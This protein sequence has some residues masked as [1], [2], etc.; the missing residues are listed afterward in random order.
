M[1]PIQRYLIPA[2]VGLAAMHSPDA[3]AQSP[4]YLRNSNGKSL[5]TPV[6][7][8]ASNNVIFAGVGTTTPSQYSPK[9]DGIAILGAG[10]GDPVKNIGFEFYITSIDLSQWKEYSAS[11]QLSR[12]LGEGSAV[13]VG[14]QRLMITDGGD[15][16]KSF[17]AVYSKGVQS[18]PYINEETGTSKLTYSIGVGSGVY[19]DKSPRDV[20]EGRG[21]HG[22]YVFG[23]IAYEVAHSFNVITDWNGLNLNAG[24]SK[25]L[26]ISRIPVG[27]TLGVADLTHNSGDG[28]RLIVALSTGFAL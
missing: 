19:G 8:G 26:F 17:Y 27:V 13:G 6:A 18:H 16:P 21:E 11:F 9:S 28:P 14:L 7:W 24:V 22:T 5:T 12:D 25:T 3:V 23:N 10:I 1:K 4:T 20:V 2:L 15:T